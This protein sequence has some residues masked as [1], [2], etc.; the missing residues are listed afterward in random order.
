LMISCYL[1]FFKKCAVPWCGRFDPDQSSTRALFWPSRDR[2]QLSPNIFSAVAVLS[3]ILGAN[4]DLVF[5]CPS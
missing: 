3:R 2:S 1:A 4:C 5:K